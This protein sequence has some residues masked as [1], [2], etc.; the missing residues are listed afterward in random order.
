MIEGPAGIGKT[1]LLLSA[2]RMS[3][4]AG[5]RILSARATELE[6][7]YAF[8]IA[9]QW[10]EP[11]LVGASAAEQE[12][13]LEGAAGLAARVLSADSGR[14]PVRIESALHSLY[15][16]LANLSSRTPLMLLLDDA[17]WADGASLRLLSYLAPRMEGLALGTVITSRPPELGE[18]GA[19]L[20]RLLCDPL[21][22]TLHPSALGSRAATEVLFNTTGSEPDPAFVTQAVAATGGNP[23][24]LT[25]LG[26][27]VRCRWDHSDGRARRS[28]RHDPAADALARDPR[29]RERRRARTRGRARGARRARRRAAGGRDSRTTPR[30]C[31]SRRRRARP[32]GAADGCATARV[33]PRDRPWCRTLRHDRRAARS[34]SRERSRGAARPGRHARSES[35]FICSPRNPRA[36]PSSSTCCERLRAAPSAEGHPTSPSGCSNGRSRSRHQ[37]ANMEPCSRRWPAPATAAG[38]ADERTA[39][40]YQQAYR[41]LT[42]PVRR[43]ELLRDLAWV[44]GPNRPRQ[45]ELEPLFEQAIDELGQTRACAR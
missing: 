36:T 1:Q 39:D 18:A 25:E 23:F 26:R 5:L 35:R 43:V 8:G 28:H 14:D 9:R 31:V 20:E 29:A 17:Q 40:L 32:G 33:P 10:L 4:T 42:D 16:A 34:H 30:S 45:R 13:L 24:Y 44:V 27:G 19:L 2:N 41:L 7:D 3:Q 38:M 21:A 6:R 37:P 22:E 12:A 15:W 11:V